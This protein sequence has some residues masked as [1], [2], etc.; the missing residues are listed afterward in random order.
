[1]RLAR[2]AN[3]RLAT[4]SYRAALV[5][6][7]QTQVPKYN[8]WAD[9][10]M[11]ETISCLLSGTTLR[12]PT[13]LQV[14][15]VQ[16]KGADDLEILRPYGISHPPYTTVSSLSSGMI[17]TS[18]VHRWIPAAKLVPA[19]NP[20]MWRRDETRLLKENV[21]AHYIRAMTN[22]PESPLRSPDS[23]VFDRLGFGSWDSRRVM[24]DLLLRMPPRPYDFRPERAHLYAPGGPD[25]ISRSDSIFRLQSIY[26]QENEREQDGW[27]RGYPRMTE[28]EDDEMNDLGVQ[29]LSPASSSTDVVMS[30]LDMSS[31]LS[32]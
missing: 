20:T 23:R 4:Y 26:K 14:F 13:G 29:N 9:A 21:E 6:I 3:R 18:P 10:V 27:Q 22:G 7:I 24:D 25:Y 30:V 12:P 1:M 31:A 28:K 8:Y 11:A 16:E 5:D 17:P 32:T 15:E 19:P 2:L